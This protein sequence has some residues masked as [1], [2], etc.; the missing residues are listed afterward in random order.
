MGDTYTPIKE[1]GLIGNLETCALVGPDGSMDWCCLP[2]LEAPSVFAAL[3]DSGR[4][5][6]FR[7]A[8]AS[9]FTADFAY[10]GDTNVLRNVFSTPTGSA[11]LTD[12]MPVSDGEGHGG[13][14]HQAILRRLECTE[15]RVPFRVDFD[16]RFDYAR[17]SPSLESGSGGVRATAG[18]QTLS[19]RSP[20][21]L[22][23]TKAGAVADFD[24]AAGQSRWFGLTWGGQRCPDDERC[25]SLLSD[26]LRFWSDW[27]HGRHCDDRC[28]FFGAQHAA[29]VRS[30][31]ILKL[32]THADSGAIAAAPT[33]SLPEVIGGARNW[34]YRYA[35]L[36]DASFTVQALH[37]AGHREEAEAYFRWVRGV[38]PHPN[39]S[40]HPPEFQIVYGLHGERRLKEEELPHL[41]GYRGSRPVRIGNAAHRQN[42]WDIYGELVLAFYETTRYGHGITVE[43]W[44]LVC[45]LAA[46]VVAHWREPD[47]G[48]WEVRGGPRH[49]T[50]SK[51]MCWVALD[52]AARMAGSGGRPGPVGEWIRERDAIRRAILEQ[53]FDERTGSFTQAFGSPVLD[54]TSLLI[55]KMGLLPYRDRRVRSTLEATLRR[56]TADGMV[57]RY[58]GEDS[59]PG[60]EGAF[61]L[62]T[63]WL[64]DAL[65]L[66]GR[67]DEAEALCAGILSRMGP[68][69]LLS[70]QMD[71]RT[72]EYLGNY[73]Q[74]FSHIG[75]LNSALY[76]ARCK[77]KRHAGPE[78]LGL[79]HP[80]HAMPEANQRGPG[81]KRESD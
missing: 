31:L 22:I 50:Y 35:W 55:P 69:G 80:E 48:I 64:V 73:P 79:E 5:G 60:R 3:L 17:T 59:L 8:P 2:H 16:P 13:S 62:C 46:E 24:L 58:L 36:R 37:N 52:R 6:R 32:L 38:R 27:A 21:P 1:Y 54:A 49:F 66:S 43:Q 26:T 18:G 74:A 57:Y 67:I 78:L 53:G 45:N 40:A 20:A 63:F 9:A 34:D 77:G 42:Q 72:G 71:P 28:L 70:E 11:T 14:S 44:A 65:A 12:F 61:V 56:L 39:S 30:E 81:S 29:V 41:A 76:L 25:E 51:L 75:L 33:T 19:L 7:I 4:G 47:S 10:L 68:L 23:V 15:G